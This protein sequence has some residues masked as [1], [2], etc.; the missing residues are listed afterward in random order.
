[1]SEPVTLLVPIEES[2]RGIGPAL[3]R[4]YLEIAGGSS[5]DGES[6]AAS[7]TGALAQL[8]GSEASAANIE[9]I[10]THERAAIDVRVRCGDRTAT[11]TQPLPAS[12]P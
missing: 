3:A 5:Q 10:F 8:V 9:M 2:Y 4:K 7:V 11:V 12:K 1:M 6:L